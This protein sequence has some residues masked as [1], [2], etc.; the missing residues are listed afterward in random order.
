MSNTTSG[1]QYTMSDTHLVVELHSVY[2]IPGESFQTQSGGG[3]GP[4]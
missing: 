3:P 1:A 4:K 2:G